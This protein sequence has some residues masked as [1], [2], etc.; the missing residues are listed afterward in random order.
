MP[1]EICERRPESL[2]VMAPGK[3]QV[4]SGRMF[5]QYLFLIIAIAIK[6]HLEHLSANLIID[7]PF[8]GYLLTKKS[9]VSN[10]DRVVS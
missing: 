3:L 9:S 1:Q 8:R 7:R 4:R 2:T 6:R 5:S 10:S